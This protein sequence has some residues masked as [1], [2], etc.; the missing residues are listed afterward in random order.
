MPESFEHFITALESVNESDLTYDYVV[1][2]LLNY[3]LRRKES[4][5]STI[6]ESAMIMQHKSDVSKLT[7]YYCKEAGHYKKDCPKL[8]AKQ[9]KHHERANNVIDRDVHGYG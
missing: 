9:K 3:D 5:V 8:A 6:G 4:G 1:A 7:C 2:K